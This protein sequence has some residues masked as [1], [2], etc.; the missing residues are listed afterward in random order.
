LEK[1]CWLIEAAGL[2]WPEGADAFED[3]AAAFDATDGGWLD[4][5]ACSRDDV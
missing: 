4:I 5:A 1:N 2:L 3:D